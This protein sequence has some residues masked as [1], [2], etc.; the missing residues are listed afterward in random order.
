M[1]GILCAMKPEGFT[2][3]DVV[4]KLRSIV[5][6]RK[7]GH[8][9]TLDPFATGVLPVFLGKTARVCDILP[10]DTKTYEA[11]FA[12]GYATD[13]LDI[14]GEIVR[15][16]TP[17]FS[18]AELMAAATRFIGDIEQIPPMY[19]AVKI[20]GKKLYQLAR[21]GQEIDRPAR[22]V[23]IHALEVLHFDEIHYEATLR[24]S[25][26]K[27]TYIRTLAD[28]LGRALNTCSI[29]KTLVRTKAGI[30]TLADCHTLD[31]IQ[32]AKDGG[33]LSTLVLPTEIVFAGMDRLD[34]T[35]AQYVGLLNGQHL[36]FD[37]TPDGTYAVYGCTAGFLGLCS[38]AAG[39]LHAKKI[40]GERR[41]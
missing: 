39:V 10:D 7:I 17:R 9:G 22:S 29:V 5:G 15:T 21:A 2:S 24:I 19:S 13:T 18:A 31:E 25:C 41:D 28:D 3:F 11:V 20:G 14:T 1:D 38:V 26:S 23:T 37:D 6:M 40:F 4:A 35:D 12:F 16:D 32:A 30:F 36:S 34:V 33:T 27:G 8:G